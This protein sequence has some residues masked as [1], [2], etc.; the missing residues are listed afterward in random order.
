MIWSIGTSLSQTIF[1]GGRIRANIERARAAHAEYLAEYRERLLVAFKEVETAL[2]AL[3]ILD[4]QH[5]SQARAVASAERAEQ[6]ATARYKS[7]LV[8]VL[9]LIDAQRTRLQV[10]RTRLQIRQQQMLA[11]VALIRAL[12]GGWA[13]RRNASGTAWIEPDR[14]R[15]GG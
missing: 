4:L 1:D 5:E 14:P 15:P 13:E 6:L 12:G 8:N 10:E 9:E 7:G 3:R 2:A 11:S